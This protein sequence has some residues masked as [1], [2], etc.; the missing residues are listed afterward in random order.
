MSDD[1]DE[2][3]LLVANALARTDWGG[4]PPEALRD[5][6]IDDALPGARAV[7]TALDEAGLLLHPGAGGTSE[8]PELVRQV[9]DAGEVRKAHYAHA[10]AVVDARIERWMALGEAR[11]RAKWLEGKG[12]E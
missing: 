1:P 6:L 3:T 11:G 2:A 4:I 12:N 7:I 9:L 10:A 8:H 5:D